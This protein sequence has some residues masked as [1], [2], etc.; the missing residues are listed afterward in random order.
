MSGNTD[1]RIL[2][3]KLLFSEPFYFRRRR[4]VTHHVLLT[5]SILTPPL[6]PPRITRWGDASREFSHDKKREST[7]YINVC[8]VPFG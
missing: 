3:N 2:N 5:A 6:P 8:L 1:S 7:L 4:R